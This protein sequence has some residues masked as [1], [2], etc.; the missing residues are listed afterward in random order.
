MTRPLL[1]TRPIPGNAIA[2]RRCGQDHAQQSRALP[3]NRPDQNAVGERSDS[4]TGGGAEGRRARPGRPRL[5]DVLLN[6]GRVHPGRAI[7]DLGGCIVGCIYDGSPAR[8]WEDFFSI[9]AL[10]CVKKIFHFFTSSD[11]IQQVRRAWATPIEPRNIM[12]CDTCDAHGVPGEAR[13]PEEGRRPRVP[14]HRP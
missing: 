4:Q 13:R 2:H 14:V 9:S 11:E 1:L 7:S 10:F 6:D 8:G 12:S 3:R 5:P